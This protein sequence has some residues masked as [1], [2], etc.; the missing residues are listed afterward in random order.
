MVA[1]P[2]MISWSDVEDSRHIL[3][4]NWRNKNHLILYY[5]GKFCAKSIKE[6]LKKARGRKWKTQHNL[7]DSKKANKIHFYGRR[8]F[9]KRPLQW[10][11]RLFRFHF[12]LS[13]RLT[14]KWEYQSNFITRAKD[15]VTQSLVL[16]MKFF[17]SFHCY[18][19]SVSIMT[20]VGY[21]VLKVILYK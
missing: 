11:N 2:Y 6:R 10:E 8:K 15:A 13:I 9:A 4:S 7:K 16:T 19:F 12:F 14:E 1:S 18:M 17:H 21:V 3:S 5:A 20:Y